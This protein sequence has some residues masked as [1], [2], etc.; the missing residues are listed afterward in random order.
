MQHAGCP[1]SSQA[2]HLYLFPLC[3]DHTGFTQYHLLPV[4]H[5]PQLLP[6]ALQSLSLPLQALTDAEELR[7][8]AVKVG[9]E[10]QADGSGGIKE[11][12]EASRE[13]KEKPTPV[14]YQQACQLLRQHQPA[15]MGTEGQGWSAGS[16]S[17]QSTSIR[18]FSNLSLTKDLPS[19]GVQQ[20]S[21]RRRQ[22]VLHWSFQSL[23][24]FRCP[25][26]PPRPPVRGVR[27]NLLG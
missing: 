17:S 1:R 5:H 13:V 9:H 21:P 4:D 27:P 20:L 3:S 16:P 25:F 19:S 15:D 22:N 12:Q 2:A 7:V 23:D 14:Y 18:C 11:E 6:T 24:I 10:E 26:S 8:H